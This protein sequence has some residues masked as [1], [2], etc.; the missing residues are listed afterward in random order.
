M[1]F[2]EYGDPTC[3]MGIGGRLLDEGMN[4]CFNAVWTWKTNWYADYH[5]TLNLAE[6]TYYA[7]TLVGI[8][9]IADGIDTQEAHVIVEV[10]PKL[11]YGGPYGYPMLYQP[12]YIM[13]NRAAGPNQDV[14]DYRDQ[15]T[16]A[17]QPWPGSFSE[18]GSNM[19]LAAGETFTSAP[20]WNGRVNYNLVVKVCSIDMS[21]SGSA[22]I[23]VY[24][25]DFWGGASDPTCDDNVTRIRYKGKF[26][27]LLAS[28]GNSDDDD[29]DPNR[30]IVA[31]SILG[32][33]FLA[34]GALIIPRH[35]RQGSR[36]ADGA[37]SGAV[38]GNGLNHD[39]TAVHQPRLA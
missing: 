13:F 38:L 11:T 4:F 34:L 8:N 37:Y 39:Q 31:Y 2:D 17:F 16:I 28:N 24:M 26:Q 5:H 29:S 27:T 14:P 35:R 3:L 10:Q 36:V 25:T 1:H 6:E 21:G 9:A 20:M 18:T 23:L 22:R 12:L 32:V 7:G 15:V 19:A 30:L 33:T